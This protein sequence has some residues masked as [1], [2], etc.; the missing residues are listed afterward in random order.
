MN[1]SIMTLTFDV[2]QHEDEHTYTHLTYKVEFYADLTTTTNPSF[3]IA[4]LQFNIMF[5]FKTLQ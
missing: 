4:F 5:Y 1:N 3:N 2:R